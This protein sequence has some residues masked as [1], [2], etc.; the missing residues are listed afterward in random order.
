M[1]TV[2]SSDMR[3]EDP[4]RVNIEWYTSKRRAETALARTIYL[5][6]GGYLRDYDPC[7]RSEALQALTSI[8]APSG[9]RPHRRNLNRAVPVLTEIYAEWYGEYWR[10]WVE[11]MMVHA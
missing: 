5:I 1:F 2:P 11:P 3:N 7:M 8:R 10:G 4:A 6:A 9:R